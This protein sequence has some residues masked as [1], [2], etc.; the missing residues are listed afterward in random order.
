MRNDL[1][2]SIMFLFSCICF[3]QINPG[4][5]QVSLSNS[6][7]AT[8]GDVFALFNN[9]AG[10]SQVLDREAGVYYSPAPFGLYEMANCFAAY[11]ETLSIGSIAVGA[12]TY[13]FELYREN[14]FSIGYSYNYQN[15]F[16][17]G[18]A[19][20]LHTVSIKN[21]GSASAFYFNLGGIAYLNN[22][23]R[24]G[25]FLY[26]VNRASFTSEQNQIPVVFN[27]GFLFDVTNKLTFHLAMEKELI[28]NAS[29][30]FGVE[31]NLI[32]YLSI[33]TGFSN[34]PSKFSA[35]IGVNYSLVR[36]DY[37]VFTHQELG[38]THQ[39]GVILSFNKNNQNSTND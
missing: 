13:G 8:N 12:M 14:K 30:L 23:L 31:Y 33:R 4:A 16:F 17:V 10:L 27:T 1:I 37:A 34:E 20:N 36:F 9:P 11:K 25:F 29:V 21:Y 6:D 18:T 15:K 38:M 24:W 5:K 22:F 3:P 32:K 7:A 39:I 19:I 26:N 28:Q 2:I 35:G